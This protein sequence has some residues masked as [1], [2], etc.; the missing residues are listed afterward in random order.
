MRDKILGAVLGLAC[1]DALGAPAEFQPQSMV[2]KRWGKL[3]DYD[4]A[5]LNLQKGR[6]TLQPLPHQEKSVRDYLA[7]LSS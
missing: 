4:T 2:Q 1:G 3:T 5:L 6:H 7:G